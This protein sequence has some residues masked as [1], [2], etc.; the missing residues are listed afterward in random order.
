MV[1][2]LHSQASHD[3]VH[4][5][6]PQSTVLNRLLYMYLTF[7]VKNCSSFIRIWFQTYSFWGNGVG[8]P[9]ERKVISS[10]EKLKFLKFG[11]LSI[12]NMRV[13]HH[14]VLWIVSWIV[15][16][17]LVSSK[18]LTSWLHFDI[19]LEQ[20]YKRYIPYLK[21]KKKT[22]NTALSDNENILYNLI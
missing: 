2:I 4:F 10:C 21:K 1:P 9:I 20:K 12:W 5:S 22:V 19:F 18:T 16:H 14:Q 6:S 7:N 13:V 3:Y 11:A 8:Q 17:P 15:L